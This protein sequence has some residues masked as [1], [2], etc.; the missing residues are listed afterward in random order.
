MLEKYNENSND[1][2]Q[3]DIFLNSTLSK[4]GLN[5]ANLGTRYFKEIIKLA[6][7]NNFTDVK[8]KDLC[9][10]LSKQLNVSI[11]K[12]NSNIYN[13]INS[14]NIA[15]AKKNFIDIFNMDFDYFYI[16]PKKFTILFLNL[17]YNT[18]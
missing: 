2:K 4:L 10:M 17:L 9:S 3:I 13:S 12:I 5:Y 18:F 6:Y 1:K 14:I 8:Y 7:F 15:L 11:R 16:S